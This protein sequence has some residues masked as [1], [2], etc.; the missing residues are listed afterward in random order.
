M[1]KILNIILVFLLIITPCLYIK[2]D[3]SLDPDSQE[4]VSKQKQAIEDYCDE[5]KTIKGCIYDKNKDV[6]TK[7]ISLNY[8]HIEGSEGWANPDLGAATFFFPKDI[9][10]TRGYQAFDGNGNAVFAGCYRYVKTE[11]SSNLSKG[12][13]FLFEIIYGDCDVEDSFIV[14]SQG[15]KL[16]S[17]DWAS[18]S[19]D[20][21]GCSKTETYSGKSQIL[22]EFSI[23]EQA[24]TLND[25][26]AVDNGDCPKVFGY[27]ANT[28]WYTTLK[29]K[30]IFSE[31]E[32]DFNIGTISFWGRETYVARPG[33]TVEDVDGKDK[34]QELLNGVLDTINKK[35]CPSKIEEMSQYSEDFVEYYQNLK[36]NNDY[37]VLW[38]AGLINEVTKKSAEEQINEA[39][40]AKTKT[41][42][43]EICNITSTQKQKIESN[44]GDKCKNGCGLSNVRTQSDSTN[45][46]CY[47]C[48]QSSQGCTYQWMEAPKNGSSCSLQENVPKLQCIG[49]TTDLACRTCL[50]NAYTAA[51][52]SD[53]QKVCMA[54]NDLAR[55][56]TEQ[57]LLKASDDAADETIKQEIEENKELR[58]EIFERVLNGGKKPTISEFGFGQESMTCTQILGPNL[59]KLV[60]TGIRTIQIIGAIL[61]I[62]KG[63][64]TLIP[65]VMAKDAEGLKKAQKTLVTMAI[66]LLCIFLL[67]YLVRWIG[68]ILGYDISCLI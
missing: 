12:T 27:T 33:C 65:A 37:R 11:D 47:C 21:C 45:A 10:L 20:S 9:P 36:N 57:E 62:V 5:N 52:L 25:W 51:G 29:N 49:T 16:C 19:F 43:Y 34:A 2:A 13:Y 39:I 3:N 50:N 23:H 14:P 48:G 60:H 61:A 35:K 56:I 4:Q 64:I 31:N 67:P 26:T 28:R 53:E 38:S 59:T 42:Q 46:K 18:Y 55:L 68:N 17:C 54:G 63:M 66:I 8:K 22:R 41:C 40:K 44:L 6:Y 32:N 1:K 58:E 30:Y 7:S 15:S 24:A